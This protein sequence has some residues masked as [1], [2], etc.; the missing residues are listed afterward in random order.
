MSKIKV[1]EIEAATGSTV[2]IPTGQTFSAKQT[3]ISYVC[4]CLR[5]LMCDV[6]FLCRN[7]PANKKNSMCLHMHHHETINYQC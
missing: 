2:T 1:N 5:K 3:I 7:F 4:L 6:R